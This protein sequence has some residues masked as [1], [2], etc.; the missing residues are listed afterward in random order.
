MKLNLSNFSILENLLE[1]YQII[2]Q[3]WRYIYLNASALKA[4][5]M[6]AEQLIGKTMMECYPGI[7]NTKMFSV[8]QSVMETQEPE[9]ISNEFAYPG[10]SKG[11]FELSIQPNPDGGIIVMSNDIT[12]MIRAQL[13]E[14]STLQSMPDSIF[15]VNQAGKITYANPHTE[16]MF[17]YQAEELIGMT[18]DIL[19]PEGKRTNHAEH[20]DSYFADPSIRKMG[21]GLRLLARR[22][23]GSE[24]P[25]DI[26]LSSIQVD[27]KT[28]AIAVVRDNTEVVQSE[29]RTESQLK[30]ITALHNIDTAITGSH[31]INLIL[32]V[33][34]DQTRNE[35]DV[36]AATIFFLNPHNQMLTYGAGIGFND[37]AIE[38]TR[39]LLGEG[40][41]GR[42]ALE[43]KMLNLHT[44]GIGLSP[45]IAK[46]MESEG[47]KDVFATPL[48]AKGEVLGVLVVFNK[49][50]LV[51][52]DEW[53]SFLITLAGQAA[54]AIESA[55]LHENLRRANTELR[56]AY[57]ATIEGWS[58]AL[59]LRDHETEGHTRRVADLTEALARE[60]GASDGELIHIRRGALLHDIGKMGIPDSIL[61]KPGKL[62]DEEWQT[63]RR[64]PLIAFELLSNIDFLK[65]AIDIPYAHHEKWDGSGYPRGLQGDSIP[66]EAR[67]FSVVDV[68][69]ALRSDR[70][71]R[72]RWSD[73][74]AL[75]YIKEQT[76]SHFEPRVVTIFENLISASD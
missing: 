55:Q 72:A 48:I 35:L 66:E 8:L 65:S 3:E 18:V 2:D 43:R 63:M 60:M 31:D 17:G 73:E 27:G 33:V 57:N 40:L 50:P 10:G 53:V 45:S 62:N 61:L 6:D 59:D 58:R 54:I 32:S 9:R 67:I 75:A 13:R 15:F 29:I 52:A 21:S 39:L 37:S 7:E 20:R 25:V 16:D 71:Y 76:G 69:D 28:E 38:R 64:H 14:R 70:P 51:A 49:A 36:D 56:L 24:L 30:H 23:D 11:W 22:K 26:S 46:L 41:T 1:G 19:L 4:A 44:S 5:K 12:S 47:F 68:W 42:A 34:L 74:K